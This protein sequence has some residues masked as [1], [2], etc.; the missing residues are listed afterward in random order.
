MAVSALGDWLVSRE[1]GL[2][3]LTMAAIAMGAKKGSF[4][5]P[6][7]LDDFGRCIGLVNQVPEVIN[8]FPEIAWRCPSWNPILRRW[9]EMVVLYENG[10]RSKVDQFLSD[11]RRVVE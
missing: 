11:L 1:T 2:S 8:H 3:S 5:V 9:N 7:D 10:Q 6:R 4:H